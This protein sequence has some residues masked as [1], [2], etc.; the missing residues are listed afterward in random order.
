MLFLL[1]ALCAYFFLDIV[2]ITSSLLLQTFF[3]PH[4]SPHVPKTPISTMPPQI[5]HTNINQFNHFFLKLFPHLHISQQAYLSSLSTCLS[6]Y[7]HSFPETN[8]HP[9]TS[10]HAA[11]TPISTM[12]PQIW[13][14]N[15]NNFF[16]K[17]FPHLHI[18]QQAYLSSLSTC[19]SHYLPSFPLIYIHYH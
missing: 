8:L 12:P 18:S 10:P 3:F 1:I 13:Y 7:F 16:L 4:T 11:K 14:I 2:S 17:L 6:H 19:L 15:I 9:H 5:W